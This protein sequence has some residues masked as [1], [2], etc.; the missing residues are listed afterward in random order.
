[1]MMIDEVIKL[2]YIM[3]TFYEQFSIK[4][5]DIKILSFINENLCGRKV[6]YNLMT[7][8]SFDSKITCL[9]KMKIY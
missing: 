7:R 8:K 6:I 4:Q 1:M 3:R 5:G 9:K 2:Y